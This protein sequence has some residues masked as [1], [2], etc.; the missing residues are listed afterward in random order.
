MQY[1]TNSGGL[2]TK[3]EAD[4]AGNLPTQFSPR[5]GA[6]P[7]KAFV[8][9]GMLTNQGIFV[10][11]NYF[12]NS[13]SM[14]EFPGNI[15]VSVGPA[16][17][18]NSTLIA[19]NG[20]ITI[21]ASCLL[22]SNSVIYADRSLTLTAPSSLGDGYV[23]GNQFGHATNATLPNVVTNGTSITVGG[24]VRITAKPATADLLGTTIT[25]ISANSLV[26]DNQWAGEDRGATPSGFADNLALGRMI[27]D[28]DG[29]PS[30]Y[31]FRNV[32]G[33]ANALY[34]D[35][36]E[37]K[38]GATNTDDNGNFTAFHFDPGIKIYFAQ[39]IM[40]GFSIAEKLDG[41]NGGG[42]LWVSN[43][44]G[45]YSSTNIPYPDGNNLYLQ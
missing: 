18:T 11:A 20:A 15:D 45:V 22:L 4:Y 19:S 27:F 12:E 9:H 14:M 28:S 24:G 8:N 42:F 34:V 2:T 13:G 41:K 23:F 6:T 1:F 37:F 40:N 17:I 25:N 10:F 39:A 36:I 44:A 7:I 31:H 21:A 30:G 16:T 43:Y 33:N 29:N 5:S 3:N 38:N 35:S 26:S 32:P